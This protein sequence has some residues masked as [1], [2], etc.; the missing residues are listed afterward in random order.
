[1]RVQ[2]RAG[3][4]QS[5]AVTDLRPDDPMAGLLDVL[6]LTELGTAHIDITGVEGDAETD[7]GESVA[8]VFVGRSQKQPHGRVY[9]GQVL[10]QCVMA[11]GRTVADLSSGRRRLHSL[12]GYFLRPGDDTHP[13]RFAVERI[14]DGRSFSA[15]RV[16]AIQYGR[17]IFSMIAS[18]QDVADGFEHQEDMPAAPPPDDV[19]ATADVY[20]AEQRKLAVETAEVRPIELRH[21]DGVIRSAPVDP[22]ESHQRV[23]LRSV[24]ALPDDPL[25]HFAVLAYFSDATLLESVLRANGLHWSRPGLRVASLDHAMWFHRDARADEW[26]LYSQESPSAQGGRGL[27]LGRIFTADGTLVATVGQEG[28]IRVKPDSPA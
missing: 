5:G 24:S 19:P 12:H 14:R 17:P 16:Q 2:R 18:F 23:W 3:P 20:G 27:S 15:R 22:P 13:I 7:L 8:T 26:L 11:A 4:L 10:A 21:V 25:I 6:D 9:G 28:M 1:M